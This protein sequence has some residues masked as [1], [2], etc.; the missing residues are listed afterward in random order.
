MSKSTSGG[1]GKTTKKRETKTTR[2]GLQFPVGRVSRQMKKSRYAKMIRGSAAIYQASVLEYLTAEILEL[3]GNCSG[4]RARITPRH[5]M[6][7]IQ[8]DQELSQLLRHATIPHAGRLP[9]IHPVLLPKNKKAAVA[10]AADTAPVT[11]VAANAPR[12]TGG[13]KKRPSVPTSKKP[14]SK[15]NKSGKATTTVAKKRIPKKNA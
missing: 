4:K 10:A 5:I 1:R 3:A 12:P 9:G 6:Q 11:T 13:A 8:G 14:S 15:K 2:A 7:A